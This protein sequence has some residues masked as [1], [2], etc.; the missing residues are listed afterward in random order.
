MIRWFADLPIERKLRVGILVPAMAVFAIGMAMHI[1]TN[2]L[3]LRED[4]QQ[5]AELLTRVTGVTVFEALQ[6]GNPQDASV[7]LTALKED[8]LVDH[9]ELLNA[10]GTRLASFSRGQDVAFVEPT[11]APPI[12]RGV[13]AEGV[14]LRER[15]LQITTRARHN[16]HDLGYVVISVP[17]DA[18]YPDLSMYGLLIAAAIGSS[19]VIA[20]WLAARLQQQISGPIVNLAH[21]MQRV[22]TEEDYCLRV[23]GNSEDEI[24]SLIDGFN[25]M[26]GADPAPRFA[27]G[28]N[29]ANSSN[30]KWRS[31]PRI[32]ATPIANCRRPSTRRPAPRRRPSAPAAPRASS[33]RA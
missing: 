21:T 2:V 9:A 32:S 27:F 4:L 5:R 6:A 11:S 7:G 1:A 23:E 31:A 17:W 15:H 12:V 20:F 10:D 3:R 26:L 14:R 33:W 13:P 24:G 18:V 25:Q 8:P 29:T 30:S 19:I 22:S 28:D 16:G